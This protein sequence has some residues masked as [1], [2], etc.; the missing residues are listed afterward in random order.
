[1]GKALIENINRAEVRHGQCAFWWLGQHGFALKLGETVIYV[2]AYLT[3]NDARTVAPLLRP[4][5]V[6]NA[7]VIIGTHDHGDHIDR[8][9]W[10]AMAAASPSATI[11]APLYVRDSVIADLGLD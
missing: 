11:V 3:P 8:D 4:E 9:S 2:D 6:T 10:P 1:T 5:E 7:D